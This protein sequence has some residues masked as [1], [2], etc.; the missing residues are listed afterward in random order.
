MTL[1]LRNAAQNFAIAS[2][3]NLHFLGSIWEYAVIASSNSK[4]PEGGRLRQCSCSDRESSAP[5]LALCIY[6]RAVR[7]ITQIRPQCPSMNHLGEIWRL[8]VPEIRHGSE[9]VT[10]PPQVTGSH[11]GVFQTPAASLFA[12]RRLAYSMSTFAESPEPNHWT[13]QQWVFS[14]CG[15][16]I[17][18][19]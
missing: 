12:A 8:I 6:S 1:P 4:F 19:N 5:E 7:H 9:R 16:L 18:S 3:R 15:M 11:I 13:T 14:F 17:G 2:P 10:Y